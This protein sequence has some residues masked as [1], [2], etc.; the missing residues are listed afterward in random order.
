MSREFG[1]TMSTLVQTRRQ[2]WLAQ[3]PLTETCRKVLSASGT[4]GVFWGICPGGTGEGCPG[5][6][7]QKGSYLGSTGACPL[8]AG[9]GAPC[10]QAAPSA[11]VPSG[12]RRSQRPVQQPV[13]QPAEGFRT[14]KR[15]PWQPRASQPNQR[16]PRA[17]GGRGGWR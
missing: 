10:P 5:K 4:R 9:L 13:Q 16:P 12:L 3:S 15:P 8:L 6:A 17:S 1:H 11:S 2:V 14:P 7:D